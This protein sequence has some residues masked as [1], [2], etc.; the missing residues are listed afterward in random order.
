MKKYFL[1][2][3]LENTLSATILGRTLII[4]PLVSRK[5]FLCKPII[6]LVEELF[7]VWIMDV[8]QKFWMNHIK[9]L[10]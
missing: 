2:I 4:V 8:A 9:S 7:I 1:N 10:V 3:V 6:L 5:V